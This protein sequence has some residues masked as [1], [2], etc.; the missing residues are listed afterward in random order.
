MRDASGDAAAPRNGF[1]ALADDDSDDDA[2][3]AAPAPARADADRPPPVFFVKGCVARLACR[4]LDVK[5]GADDA[6]HLL[7]CV[8]DDASV[9]EDYWNGKVF[10]PVELDAPPYLTF[11]GSQTF[12]HVTPAAPAKKRA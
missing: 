5:P 3:T 7:T 8:I 1:A 12:G 4:V 9:R 6:H 11:L 10:A 2:S